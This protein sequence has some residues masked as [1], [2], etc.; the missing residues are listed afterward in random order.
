M[1]TKALASALI[2]FGS[3]AALAQVADTQ[4]TPVENNVQA[5]EAWDGSTTPETT[6]PVPTDETTPPAPTEEPMGEPSEDDLTTPPTDPVP[7]QG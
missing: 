1:R 2:L 3:T 6:E 5:E 7:P 4:D